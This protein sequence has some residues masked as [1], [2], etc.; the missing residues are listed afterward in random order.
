MENQ[1]EKESWHLSK[2]I[3]VTL[4]LAI[5]LQSLTAIWWAGQF[6][7]TTEQR[8]MSLE[9]NKESMSQLPERMA[10]LEAV[11]DRLDGTLVRIETV[12]VRRSH[13]P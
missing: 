4:I 5:V 10:R 3:P 13:E 2:S 12:L 8:L 11:M 6:S 1:P 9:R 7:A